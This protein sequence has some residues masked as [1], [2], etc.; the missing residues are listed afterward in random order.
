MNPDTLRLILQITGVVVGGGILEFA[1]R[2]LARRAEL[3]NLNAQSDATISNSYK[4]LVATLTAETKRHEA[5]VAEL[6][7]RVVT[8]ETRHETAQRQF[9]TQLNDAHTENVRLAT[10]VAQLTT[11]LDIANRQVDDLRYRSRGI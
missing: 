10:R 1:R 4:D 2:M 11:D 9:T 7:E 3:R 8:L 6:Q 5:Q